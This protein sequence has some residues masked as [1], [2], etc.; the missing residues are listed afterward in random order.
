MLS[1]ADKQKIAAI[2]I[3][4]ANLRDK[5][6]RQFPYEGTV[7]RVKGR[8]Y[9]TFWM[10][11]RDWAFYI[12]AHGLFLI[13]PFVVFFGMSLIILFIDSYFWQIVLVMP[14]AAGSWGLY[15]VSRRRPSAREQLDRI[16]ELLDQGGHREALS[17]LRPLAEQG[18]PPAQ[19]L[20]GQLHA[21]GR[22]VAKSEREAVRWYRAA[23]ERGLAE[24]QYCLGM[25][26]VDGRGLPKSLE[27]GMRWY[28][29]A[30]AQGLKQAE[31]SL[32]H[33]REIV[34]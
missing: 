20:I 32:A 6:E 15:R 9:R 34:C 5:T 16:L 18:Y 7:P 12:A 10:V 25:M 1:E 8:D 19:V 31:D 11:L 17:R 22:A 13:I 14:I 23:A 24:A 28:E 21:S 26:H 27:K 2:Q 30:A 4:A 29:K 33:L 3:K